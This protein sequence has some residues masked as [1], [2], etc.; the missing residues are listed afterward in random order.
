MMSGP[1]QGAEA[2]AR[3][4]MEELMKDYH[5]LVTKGKREIYRIEG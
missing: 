5:D 2:A 3:K 1:P 4:E